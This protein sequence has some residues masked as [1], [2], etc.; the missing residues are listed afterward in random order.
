[1]AIGARVLKTGLAVTLAIAICQWL[2]IKPASFA[3]ITAVIN[4]QPSVNKALKDAGEQIIVHLAAVFLAVLLGYF[5]GNGPLIIGLAVIFMIVIANRIGWQDAIVLGIIS[6]I[7][8][9]DAPSGDFLKHAGIRSSAIFIGLGVA[10]LINWTLAPPKYKNLLIDNLLDLFQA[11]SSYFLES[12]WNFANPVELATYQSIKPDDLDI[13]LRMV[14]E[15]HENARDELTVEDNALLIERLIELCIGFI[16]RGQIIENMIVERV[17]RLTSSE[18][19]VPFE[20]LSPE[21]QQILDI[22]K[23]G[24]NRV[25]DVRDQVWEGLKTEHPPGP[26]G[27]DAEYWAEFDQVMSKWQR[28]VSGEFYLRA[29]MEVAVVATEMRWAFRRLRSIYNLGYIKM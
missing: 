19:I 17:K 2:E 10:L 11:S 1:M 8:I 16:E 22:I 20:H 3:A 26:R 21:F 28:K 12:L 7:F 24:K 9:L 5:L 25:H 4:M 29:M 27:N 15:T 18:T 14:L 23:L 13:K 6:I